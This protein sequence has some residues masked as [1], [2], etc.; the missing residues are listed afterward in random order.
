MPD[1]PANTRPYRNSAEFPPF[2]EVP[3][4]PAARRAALLREIDLLLDVG[5]NKGQYAR[6]IRS[7]GFT[8]RIVSFEPIA[9]QF[10]ELQ[11]AARSGSEWDCYRL[12]LGPTNG[13]LDLHVSRDTISTSAFEPTS[14][15]LALYPEAAQIGV[16]RVPMRTLSSLWESLGC[17]GK[18]VYL[19][20]DAEGFELK[21]LDG[22][23]GALDGI[24]IIELEICLM[25]HY[26]AA[27]LL[28]DV[29]DYMRSRRFSVVAIEPN[30]GD[31]YET[32]QT[33]AVEGIFRADRDPHAA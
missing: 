23:A 24:Q 12:A 2:S 18:R 29:L 17:H 3:L 8:G 7:V 9:A 21:V 1:L 32:G 20:I 15:H 30:L 26:R 11:D 28:P 33:L 14:E 10:H 6:W 13:D 16:E 25:P 31:D 22:A 4:T 19:K 27:P 5:A